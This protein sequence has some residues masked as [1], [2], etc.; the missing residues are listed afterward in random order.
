VA[1]PPDV[2]WYV[3]FAQVRNANTAKPAI[4]QQRVTPRVIHH[5]TICLSGILCVSQLQA[6]RSLLDF[7]E[8]ALDNNGQAVLTWAD[9][10]QVPVGTRPVRATD[11]HIFFGKQLTGPSAY[12]Q[13]YN[14]CGRVVGPE[15][16]A[17]V[18]TTPSAATG[19]PLPN[20]GRGLPPQ[21]ALLLSATVVAAAAMVLRRRSAA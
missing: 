10:G 18:S 12:S 7:F 19:G 11:N 16:A 20:T 21:A 5:G 17:A 15:A 3:D 13:Q 4:E 8:V 2:S 14:V 1:K 9:N 6:D